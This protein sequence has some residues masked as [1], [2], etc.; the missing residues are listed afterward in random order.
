MKKLFIISLLFCTSCTVLE[1]EPFN[2]NKTIVG[3]GGLYQGTIKKNTAY[4]RNC[5]KP[6]PFTEIKQCKIIKNEKFKYDGVDIYSKGLP[7]NK[8]CI[9]LGNIYSQHNIYSAALL[10]ITLD[11]NVI[12]TSDIS[13][14]DSFEQNGA[15][16]GGSD[17]G[18][19]YT[20]NNGIHKIGTVYNL[21]EC[22]K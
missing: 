3:Q 1:F 11:A 7:N 19:V 13:F 10:A 8:N 20:I 9:F 14:N 22:I 16:I 6:L 12:T 17:A 4:D 2:G 5:R 15:L 21:F 18:S